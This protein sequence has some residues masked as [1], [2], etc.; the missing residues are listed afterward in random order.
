MKIYTIEN[1][2]EM[3]FLLEATK[4][5]KQDPKWHP[6]EDVFQH[7]LQVLKWALRESN[8][9]DVV[10]TA[11]LHDVGKAIET[12]GHAEIS[13][14]LLKD[15]AAEKT[16]FLIRNHRRIWD[17]L[18]GSMHKLEKC[19]FLAEHPWLPELIQ[20]ARFDRKG[21]N[22]NVKIKYDKENIIEKLNRKCKEHFYIPEHLKGEINYDKDV[23][24][25]REKKNE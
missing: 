9:I 17:Y 24:G 11:L 25:L 2:K 8:D 21:R 5:V 3:F 15:L 20:L 1:T 19:L 12:K 13:C 4:G 18:D 16:L 7:S 6:E 10:L 14:E 22:P 23:P